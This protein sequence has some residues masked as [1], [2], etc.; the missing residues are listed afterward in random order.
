MTRRRYY[1]RC[2]FEYPPVTRSA[3]EAQRAPRGHG[4]NDPRLTASLLL[5]DRPHLV[6]VGTAA[7]LVVGLGE[8]T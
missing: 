2:G 5:V 3:A 4:L 6:G 8:N 7:Q 1:C